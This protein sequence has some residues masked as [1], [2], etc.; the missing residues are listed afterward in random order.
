MLDLGSLKISW[1]VFFPI[2]VPAGGGSNPIVPETNPF[3]NP[4][5]QI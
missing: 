1:R 4:T 2:F 3:P 5:G